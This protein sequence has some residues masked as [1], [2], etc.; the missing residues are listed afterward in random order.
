MTELVDIDTNEEGLDR[1]AHHQSLLAAIEWIAEQH[2]R[3]FSGATTLSGLPI[4]DGCLTV[5]NIEGAFEN[6]GLSARIVRKS[7]VNVPLIVC[8]FMVFFEGGD[9][10]IV[11]GRRG[12]RGK[13]KVIV[14]G[15]TKPRAISQRELQ[16]QTSNIVVYVSP[17]NDVF[18]DEPNIRQIAKGHWL[19]ATVRR[20]WG[21]W[22]QVVLVAFLVNLLGLALP[23]FIM[24]VYDRVIPY[25]A[26]PTLWALSIGVV[27]AL[28]FDFI[29]R[30]LRAT[31]IDNAGRRIDMKVS[32]D[33]FNHVLDTKMSQRRGSAG[34]IASSVREFE[35]VRDFFTSASL[36]SA[37]DL[38]FIGV[39]LAVL[40]V[41]VGP[42]VLVPLVAVPL[43]L[44]ATLLIQIPMNKSVITGLASSNN[45]HSVLVESLVGVE[46]IKASSAEGPFQR[47]WEAAV[48]DTVRATSK[49]RF[50]S[51][52]A[53]FFCMSVQQM[54]S[55]I[56]VVW[57]VYLVTAG[58]ISVGALIASNILAGRVLA[59]LGG[60]A[61]TLSRLQQSVNALRNLGQLMKAERD[62]GDD[63][64]H[65]QQVTEGRLDLRDV[66]FNYP[67][68]AHV[69]LK[70][71]NI[72]IQPGEKIGIIGRVGSGKSTLG[73]LLCGLFESSD[74]AIVL[75][76]IDLKHRRAADVRDAIY[77]VPQE[78][79]LFS[80]T[81][82][83]NICFNGPV[84]SEVFE[85]ASKVAGVEAFVQQ[86]PLGFEMPVGERGRNLSG[87]Q[88]QAVSLARC[89]VNESRIL[90]LDEPTSAMD[91]TT[92]AA[93]VK[94]LKEL[95]RQDR[96]ILIATHRSTLLDLVDRIIVLEQGRVVADGDKAQVLKELSKGATSN[97]AG[98]RVRKNGK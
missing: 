33:V 43:V 97:G 78:A 21:A 87:G 62:H 55:V 25:Q 40:W 76:D 67:N 1:K 42:L 17:A 61:M 27:L 57:G 83:D 45:R 9:V 88:R 23:L 48:A 74:G 3:Q 69:V 72:S 28:V 93:F 81:I 46:T 53:I 41:I 50:W 77:Y 51:S 2:Q 92:E 94:H 49:T 44:V 16:R 36:T 58:D 95:Q 79:D 56:V 13:F 86:E 73:K 54:V 80:G 22:T 91:T 14:G 7:P 34:E 26:I 30:M 5:A 38:L 96:T 47:R 52:L 71:I 60:I 15:E 75:D 32:S 18:S 68:G 63:G 6:L 31:V 84:S 29:L 8:P 12:K 11:T 64:D 35:S 37:I 39:F 90:F 85:M 70:G 98:K 19:W 24:N 4:Q 20:F 89:L 82:R 65:T 66:Q 10:G 59:P